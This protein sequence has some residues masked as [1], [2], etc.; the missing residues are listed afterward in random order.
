MRVVLSGIF[1]PM[2]IIRY[3]EAALKRRPD[4]ELHTAGP[5]T[6]PS[7]PWNGG[8]NLLPKYANPPDTATSLYSQGRPVPLP[9]GFMEQKLPWTPDVWIQVDAGWHL[10]GRPAKAKNIIIATDPHVLD[11]SAQRQLADT[12][13]CMQTPYMQDGDKHLPYAY[14]PIWHAPEKQPQMFDACLLGL[15]YHSRDRLVAQLR[16]RGMTVNYDLGPCFDEARALYNQAPIGLNW[17]SK[18]DLTARVFELLGM[19]RLAIVNEVPDLSR[20]FE[21]GKHLAVFKTIEEAVEKAAY[22]LDNPA[23]RW[24]IMEAG[25]EAVQGHSWDDRVEEILSGVA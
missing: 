3:F 16:A 13:Y 24:A 4:V 9:I 23:E 8:M 15:H 2:A 1:Y 22:Y 14:D 18:Q 20:F 19:G 25:L 21:D 5:Y 11:Y 7:I 6:G 17:S 12:F 10:R